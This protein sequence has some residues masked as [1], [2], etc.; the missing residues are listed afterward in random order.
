MQER[1]L[2]PGQ[3]VQF[4]LGDVHMPALEE[5]LNRITEDMEL[6]GSITLMSD[7]GDKQSAFAVV[8]VKGVLTPIIVPASA[9]KLLTEEITARESTP[10]AKAG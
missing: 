8:E 6:Q 3:K 9:I 5:V 2:Q 10:V 7:S 4:R 1:R